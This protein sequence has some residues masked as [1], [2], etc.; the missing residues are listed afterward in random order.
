MSGFSNVLHIDDD[1]VEQ[2][3]SAA[4]FLC[5]SMGSAVTGATLY[6]DNGLNIMGVST[7]SPELQDPEQ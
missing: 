7:D 4:A 2:V 1:G 3:G 5:S 6:V